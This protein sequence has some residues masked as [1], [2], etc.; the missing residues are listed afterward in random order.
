MADL[1]TPVRV[2]RYEL[3]SRIVMAP[4]TRSRSPGGVPTELVRLYYEQRASAGL[5]VTE[6][7][8]PVRDGHGY[9]ASPGLHTGEQVAAWRKVTDAVHRRAG[10]IFAQLMHVGRISHP[11]LLDGRTPIAP[12]PVRPAGNAHT[13]A[14]PAPFVTPR[15]MTESD[16]AQ[17][18]A[19]FGRAARLAL[20]AGFDGVEIHGA[21]G[22]LPH[23]F[24]ATNTNRRSDAWGGSIE[25]R[26]RL[27]LEITRAAADAIGADRVGVRISPDYAYNSIVEDDP[28]ALYAYVA[29]QLDAEGLA[30][31]HVVD[32]QPGWDVPDLI[33]GHYRG[34][35]ILNQGY[36]RARADSDIADGR[37]DLVSFGVPFI[38]NPDLPERLRTGARLNAPDPSTFYTSGARGYTDYPTLDQ[39]Q[40]EAA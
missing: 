4:M 9:V 17:A 11:L 12:S 5:I 24:L 35:L 30:Y 13:E 1:F 27:L 34:T 39:S 21:N 38:A 31:L 3:S 25:N 32:A 10:R 23:Q 2:G 37:A 36:D 29:E 18:I 7:I 40:A 33:L 14:G 20:S 6:A 28:Q 8:A 15:A 19:G 16:I 22:Y 26:A